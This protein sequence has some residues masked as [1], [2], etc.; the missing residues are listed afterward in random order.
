MLEHHADV[1]ADFVDFFQIV[2]QLS[3]VHDYLALLM[4]FQPV[5]AADQRR[6]AGT[7]WPANHDALAAPDFQV[8]VAQHVKLAVPL[9]HGDDLDGGF[10]FRRVHDVPQRCDVFRRRSTNSE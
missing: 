8:D 7:G 3:A 10:V 5:D 4:L 6:F 1:A 2:G 9:V